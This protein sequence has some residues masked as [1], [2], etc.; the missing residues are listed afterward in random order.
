MASKTTCQLKHMAS[1]A[2]FWKQEFPG[3]KVGPHGIL[4]KICQK[5]NVNSLWA[6]GKG[7]LPFFNQKKGTPETDISPPAR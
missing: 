6:S 5:A 2:S 3:V 1:R 7:A 4:C